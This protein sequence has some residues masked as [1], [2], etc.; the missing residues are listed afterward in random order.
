[1]SEASEPR[2]LAWLRNYSERYPGAWKTAAKMRSDRGKALPYWPD[3]CYLPLSGGLALASARG[4]DLGEQT[5]Q[6]GILAALA[7]WRITKGIYRYDPDVLD[8]VWETPTGKNIPTE[9]LYRLPEWCC[10]VETPGKTLPLGPKGEPRDLY[11][12]FVHLEY[13]VY[14]AAQGVERRELRFVLDLDEPVENGEAFL[15]A[16]PMHLTEPTLLGCLR[17][18]AAESV[19]RAGA[20]GEGR[21]GA[22]KMERFFAAVVPP[23]LSLTL[24][25][26]S[27]AEIR[28]RDGEERRPTN[29]EP[30]RTKKDKAKLFAAHSPTVWEVGYRTGTALRSSGTRQP[31]TGGEVGRMV[32]EHLRRAH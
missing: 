31:G 29:P 22:D 11:G 12:F 23:L 17:E 30:K 4:S 2:P 28:S 18:T 9:V 8:A 10:Y 7:A 21:L 3:W 14:S 19:A 20:A 6:A 25:L 26:C 24:Y 5:R 16:I 27:A 32:G 1:M 15:H 13:N